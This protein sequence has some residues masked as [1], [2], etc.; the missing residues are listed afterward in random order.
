MESLR[1]VFRGPTLFSLYIN[2]LIEFVNCN[3]VFYADDTVIIGNDPILLNNNLKAIQEWCN[4]NFLTINCKK[5]QWMKTTFLGKND[6][7]LN[8]FSINGV[9][10]DGV[11]EYRYLGLL[12]D[13]Q[14][15]FQS[16]RD[17]L[18]NNINYKLCFFKKIRKFITIEAASLI[19]KGT[20]LPILEYVDF[21]FDYDIQYIISYK[22]YKIKDYIPSLINTI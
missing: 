1:A 12:V 18:V 5:S 4:K 6:D 7:N 20:I 8:G 16:H 21:V 13:S 3:I 22:H 2:D 19:F 10:L 11:Q 17:N 9:K 15:N 14:L